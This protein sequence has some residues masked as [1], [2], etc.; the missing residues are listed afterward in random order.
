[1]YLTLLD[2]NSNLFTHATLLA[3]FPPQSSPPRFA[4]HTGTGDKKFNPPKAGHVGCYSAMEDACQ[5]TRLT[6]THDVTGDCA[7]A[8]QTST[9]ITTLE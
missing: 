7:G 2:E 9:F 6:T 3:P 5:K 1:M 8:P 4:N